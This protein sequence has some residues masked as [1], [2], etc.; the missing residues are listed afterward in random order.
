MAAMSRTTAERVAVV[1]T[2]LDAITDRLDKH[3]EKTA[4]I[5]T[6]LDLLL[7]GQ[8]D[9]KQ[10]RAAIKKRLEEIEPDAKTVRDA[11]TVLKWG[12]WSAAGIGSAVG[13][14]LALKGWIVVNWKWMVGT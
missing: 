2:K 13:A 6:K 14:A 1:E 11:K 5:N 9:G 4:E 10:D 12:G 3:D 8:Q 7:Q